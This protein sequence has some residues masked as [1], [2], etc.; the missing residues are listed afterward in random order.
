MTVRSGFQ[1][2]LG[3]VRAGV[4]G[5]LGVPVLTD[6]AGQAQSWLTG[7]GDLAFVAQRGPIPVAVRLGVLAH[8]DLGRLSDLGRN[9]RRASVRRLWGTE[10]AAFAGH[11]ARQAGT[12]EALATYQRDVLQPLELELLAGHVTVTSTGD[13]IALIRD[14]QRGDTGSGTAAPS[15]R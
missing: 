5:A 15:L 8:A 7:T 14:R 9:C 1:I 3:R 12:A 11:I 13:L 4:R 10:M 2:M 6:P